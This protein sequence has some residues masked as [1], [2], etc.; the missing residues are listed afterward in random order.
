MNANYHLLHALAGASLL[1]LAAAPVVAQSTTATQSDDAGARE[2]SPQNQTFL[3]LQAGLGYSTNPELRIG[4]TG[5]AFGRVSAYGFH[6]W[7]SETSNSSISAYVENSSYFRRYGNKQLFSL[8]ATNSTRL[9]EKWSVFGNVGLSGDFGAQLSSRFFGIPADAVIVDPLIPDTSTIL[10]T[11]DLLAINQRQYRINGLAGLSYILTP[12]DTLSATVGAQRVFFK[13]GG[14]GGLLDYTMYD[15]SASYRRQLS[16]RTAVGARVLVNRTDYALGRSITSYGP[17]LTGE[18]LLEEN[19]Q[20]AGAIGVVRTDRN[21]GAT[22]ADRSSTD[23]A[24]DG[25][26]CRSFEY[27]R[28]CGR[29]SRRSQSASIG[30]AQTSSV[31]AADYSRRLSARDQL[32]ASLAF[33]TTDAVREVGIGS[34][35]R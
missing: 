21:F 10:V 35:L 5:S 34:T 14:S 6:G 25:S 26:L 22:G 16:E 19:L 20:L 33:V 30:T 24:F 23:L 18:L 12:R 4:G 28:F 29:V 15:A 31:L 7:G 3:D 13:G 11:P 1:T 8:S 17:Q 2:R 9:N 27:E 32:Q